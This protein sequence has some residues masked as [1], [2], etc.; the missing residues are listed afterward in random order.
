ML[1]NDRFSENLKFNQP[2]NEFLEKKAM[3]E[4]KEIKSGLTLRALVVGVVILI[5]WIMLTIF[6]SN[7]GGAREVDVFIGSFS[8]L[9]PF[10][11][12][13]ALPTALSVLLPRL[14]RIKMTP[15]ELTVIWTILLIG[16]PISFAGF[17]AGRGLLN[18]M[19]SH[20]TEKYAPPEGWA[21]SFWA[22]PLSEVE[23]ALPGG[24]TPNWTLWATPIGF[25]IFVTIAWG[26][27]CIFMMQLFR[28]PWVEVERL[29]F[30]LAQPV[31]ELSTL[32]IVERL[33]GEM[34]RR[35]MFLLIG[36]VL[37]ILWYS[38]PVLTLIMPG[39][40]RDVPFTGLAWNNWIELAPGVWPYLPNA[41]VR[42]IFEP[43][44]IAAFV[45]APLNVTLSGIMFWLI[46][47]VVIPPIETTMGLTSPPVGRSSELVYLNYGFAQE[48]QLGNFIL[49]EYGMLFGIAIWAIILQRKFIIRTFKSIFKPETI[50]QTGEPLSYRTTWIG[51]IVCALVF[52]VALV[53]S[54]A[55]ASI[56]I[57]TIVWLMVGYIGGARLRAETGGRLGHPM[58]I[59]LHG[60][61]TSRLFWGEA[62]AYNSGFYATAMWHQFFQRDAADSVPAISVL[63]A[64]NIANVEK[65]RNR[66]VFKAAV[67]GLVVATIATVLL[68][69]NW[70]YIYG[71]LAR[72]TGEGW[73]TAS[74]FNWQALTLAEGGFWDHKAYTSNIWGQAIAG[75]FFA[76]ALNVIRL[77]IPWLPLNPVA[78]PLV[79]SM[80]GPYW[81]LPMMI[82]WVV[83]YVTVQVGGTKLYETMLLPIAVGFII[84]TIFIWGIGILYVVLTL[85]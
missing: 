17:L 52:Y 55:P 68:F 36:M 53:V 73:S 74:F 42:G 82:A 81:W 32:T 40:A 46:F 57:F 56:S 7:H 12:I 58:Y 21:P 47:W 28:R 80:M 39:Y 75:I 72:W 63:E 78:A 67:I 35:W 10:F 1:L 9:F 51:F 64:Y 2:D 76:I 38:E 6:A 43:A 11:I 85:V 34:R 18:A 50:D 27:M 24:M 61:F 22:P 5:L 15:Q 3:V 26:L 70:T 14:R 20:T 66:D 60:Q 49:G 44:M 25:W 84:G 69:V 59:H 41:Y 30:V 48:G 45:L 13:A 77:R 33:K 29:S 23:R 37:G 31:Q 83:K 19:Y 54:G 79:M 65:A 62:N 71:A 8:M 4:E 16:V